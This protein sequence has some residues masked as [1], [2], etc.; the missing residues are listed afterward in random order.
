[1]PFLTVNQFWA[2]MM[3]NGPIFTRKATIF[4]IKKYIFQRLGT[5]MQNINPFRTKLSLKK[6]LSLTRLNQFLGSHDTKLALVLLKK[7]IFFT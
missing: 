4:F 1:M 2:A 3:L 7:R 5:I 6:M